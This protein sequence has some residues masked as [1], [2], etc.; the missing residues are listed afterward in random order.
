MLKWRK[1]QNN[2]HGEPQFIAAGFAGMVAYDA[3]CSV[4]GEFDFF[5]EPIP[6][7]Y[8]AAPYLLRRLPDDIAE[9]VGDAR[10]FLERGL[11]QAIAA[12]LLRETKRGLVVVESRLMKLDPT[13]AERQAAHRKK[14]KEAAEVAARNSDSQLGTV[15]NARL[16]E[17]R[18]DLKG[19]TAISARA[20]GNNETPARKG[21]TSHKETTGGT[22][23]APRGG[24]SH[25]TAELERDVGAE[26]L[27]GPPPQIAALLELAELRRMPGPEPPGLDETGPPANARGSP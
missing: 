25:R 3:V 7:E 12:G 26:D 17:T 18:R 20:R 24:E 4:V 11:R 27:G 2:R 13:G 8:T 19:T 1:T 15:S 9:E 10:K 5:D 14:R 22:R 6:P 16:E 23:K 21:K